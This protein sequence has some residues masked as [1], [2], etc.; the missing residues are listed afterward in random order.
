MS[1]KRVV[2]VRS[3]RHSEA[4][5]F[6]LLRCERCKVLLVTAG[7]FRAGMIKCP[8]CKFA[9]SIERLGLKIVDGEYYFDE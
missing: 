5:N 8:E 7:E 9:W 1:L 4:G 6:S 3:S 2:R